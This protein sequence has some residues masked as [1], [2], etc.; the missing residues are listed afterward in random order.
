MI[1]FFAAEMTSDVRSRGVYILSK[2]LENIYKKG[3]KAWRKKSEATIT[4][5]RLALFKNKIQR[6]IWEA[7]EKNKVRAI[8]AMEEEMKDVKAE[9]EEDLQKDEVM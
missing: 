1:N 7:S 8:E 5:I 6:E 2:D 3:K 4:D 9:L